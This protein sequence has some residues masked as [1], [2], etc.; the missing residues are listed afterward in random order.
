MKCDAAS[1]YFGWRVVDLATGHK[2]EHVIWVDPQM[3]VYCTADQ[4]FRVIAGEVAKTIH[5]AA[6]ITEDFTSMTFWVA[7]RAVTVAPLSAGRQAEQEPSGQPCPDCCQPD[8][9]RR[10]CYCAAHRCGFGEAAP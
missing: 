2:I 8:A 7:R 3:K 1:G 5:V 9:C 4:P 10:I 6:D